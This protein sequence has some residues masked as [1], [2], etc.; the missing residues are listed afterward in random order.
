[1][2]AV[3]Y[4]PQ[5]ICASAY[6]SQHELPTYQELLRDTREWLEPQPDQ[7]WLDLGCGGGQLTRALWEKS[8]GA[9]S[10]I[11]GMDCAPLNA[12]AYDQL[13]Q[14]IRPMPLPEQIDFVAAD[15]ETGL[16]RFDGNT[17]HGVVSG[18]SIQYADSYD[19]QTERWTTEAYDTA[20][21]QVFRILRPSGTFVFSV[22]VPNPSWS[23]VGWESFTAI[24]HTKNPVRFLVNGFRMWKFGT[25]VKKEAAR[26]RFHYLPIE[27]ITDKL[28]QTGFTDIEHRLTYAEQAYLVRCRKP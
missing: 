27:T 28:S 12:K 25:W 17:M 15:F 13:R 10:Q 4:W 18:L 19:L 16:P 6:W 20:L 3:N 2:S 7:S 11:I 8:R 1:M 22:N 14:E 26:G 21:S 9:V 23:R 5:N 24:F